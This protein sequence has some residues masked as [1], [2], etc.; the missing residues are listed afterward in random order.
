MIFCNKKLKQRCND[1]EYMLLKF[2][3]QKDISDFEKELF[4][5]WDDPIAYMAGADKEKRLYDAYI[6]VSDQFEAFKKELGR[7]YKHY[8][9]GK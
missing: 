4:N 6:G 9:Y 1:L 2:V 7:K 5:M 8:R 3:Q